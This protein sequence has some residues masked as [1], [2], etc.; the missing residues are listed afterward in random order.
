MAENKMDLRKVAII[1]GCVSAVFSLTAFIAAL[2]TKNGGICV[3][4]W[5]ASMLCIGLYFCLARPYFSTGAYKLDKADNLLYL[6]FGAALVALLFRQ[7]SVLPIVLM[8][9]SA[10]ACYIV[11][12]ADKKLEPKEYTLA[13]VGLAAAIYAVFGILNFGGSAFGFLGR[14][15]VSAALVLS[16]IF[17]VND[18]LSDKDKDLIKEKVKE[19]GD[20]AKEVADNVSEKAKEVAD[21]VADKAKEMAE[22]V[23]DAV[24]R[25]GGDAPE[26]PEPPQE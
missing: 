8:A 17:L 7:F 14:V 11:V 22:D 1:A 23:K 13:L 12:F 19:A 26:T 21:T 10:V 18:H 9:L 5:F 2:F 4:M 25:G 6:I 24:K 20:K 16:A 15:L 3:S